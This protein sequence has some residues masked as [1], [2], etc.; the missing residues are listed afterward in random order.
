MLFI[1][2]SLRKRIRNGMMESVCQ[3]KLLS[4]SFMCSGMRAQKEQKEK[5]K[6]RMRMTLRSCRCRSA[7][8]HL[9]SFWI[10]A[11]NSPRRPFHRPPIGASLKFVCLPN[12]EIGSATLDDHV[13]RIQCPVTLGAKMPF[14]WPEPAPVVTPTNCRLTK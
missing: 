3:F 12:V 7:V 10:P 6:I 5:L 2:Y 9:I 4:F 14:R 1:G 11:A 8:I 13:I